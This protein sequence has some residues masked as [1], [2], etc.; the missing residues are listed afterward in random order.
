M[1]AVFEEALKKNISSC[2]LLP[3]Y[4]LFGDDGYLK[5]LYA[6][7][8]S[9]KIADPNDIFA[10]S[11]F[12]AD[13]NLQ[14]VYDAVMQIPIT[15][16]RKCVI[17]EDYD[18][19]H[20]SKSD[21]DR[22]T[23]LLSDV[24]DTAVL[25][26]RFIAVEFDIKKSA[27]FKKLV[28]AAEKSGGMA[29]R[30]DH[31]KAP[32]LIKM[33][34]DG[35]AKRGCKMDS[36]TARYLVEGSGDDISILR[37]ELEKLCLFVGEGIITRETV[38]RVSVKTTE[39]SVYNLSRYIISCDTTSALSV[40]DE[41]FFMRVEPMIILYTVSSVY[42]DMFRIYCAKAAGKGISEV[43]AAY[44]YK[45]REF[46]LDKAATSLKKFDFKKL[47]LSLN[48]LAEADSS[49]KSFGADARI[50]LEQL[51]IRLIYIIAKGESID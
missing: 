8:I 40:L 6:D 39:A 17:L 24:P 18:F 3:V 29:V 4:I 38:D 41:L 37:N 31:R 34:C 19:E 50:I 21:F 26:M 14:E 30:L 42:A 47:S 43:S 25:I 2:E 27:K 16:D 32:E 28:V 15:S 13:C 11:K 23:E 49:L 36:G 33:L 20:C 7:K 10:Y 45:G 48:A 35:A 22:L 46:V 12:N 9:K 5:K 1:A 44:G 51:I